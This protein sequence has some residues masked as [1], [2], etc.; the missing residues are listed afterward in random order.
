MISCPPPFSLAKMNW[1]A[2]F[3]LFK[4]NRLMLESISCPNLPT[5]TPSLS[6]LNPSSVLIFKIELVVVGVKLIPAF[7]NVISVG[8]S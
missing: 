4:S 6:K 1:N 8:S 3:S 7:S 2:L 5:N